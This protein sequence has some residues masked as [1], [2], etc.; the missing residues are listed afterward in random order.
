[1]YPYNEAINGN[2]F[3]TSRLIFLGSFG[4]YL[5]TSLC[6]YILYI[7]KRLYKH[8][9]EKIA[10]YIFKR[11]TTLKIKQIVYLKDVT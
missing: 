5:K 6:K 10:K 4:I 3:V 2:S 7:F 1:M 9:F 11:L 8:I